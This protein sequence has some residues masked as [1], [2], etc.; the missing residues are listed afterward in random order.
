MDDVCFFVQ[1]LYLLNF[2]VVGRDT[3]QYLFTPILDLKEAVCL[4]GT[5]HSADV[6]VVFFLLIQICGHQNGHPE[7]W[8]R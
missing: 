3:N 1:Y 4:G 2:E 5:L 6:L 7:W 8:F